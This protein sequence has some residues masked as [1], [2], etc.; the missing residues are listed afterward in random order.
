M[1]AA[2]AT[3]P[4]ITPAMVPPDNEG[5]AARGRVDV[6]VDMEVA[7]VLGE[8]AVEVARTL[9]FLNRLAQAVESAMQAKS[10]TRDWRLYPQHVDSESYPH[11][12]TGISLA[13]Y[14]GLAKIVEALMDNSVNDTEGALF[15]ATT[16]GPNVRGVMRAAAENGYEDVIRILVANG[17]D[18]N[19]GCDEDEG[20][21]LQAAAMKGSVL[22]IAAVNG[23]ESITGLLLKNGA[24]PNTKGG[25]YGFA[26]QAAVEEGHENIIQMLLDNGADVNLEGGPYGNAF[27][28]AVENSDQDI[29]ELLLAH[30]ANINMMIGGEKYTA[31]QEVARRGLEPMTALHQA[32]KE[33]QAG[34]VALLLRKGAN[35]NSRDQRGFTALDWA[36]K[37]FTEVVRVL[38]AARQR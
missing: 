11:E 6:A 33:G 34:V 24:D 37:K 23:D 31:L 38:E 35:P 26:L 29:V 30:G 3:E 20:N 19:A 32:A 22:H 4:T 28:A 2:P 8:T 13:A 27:Q 15:W 12:V 18:V 1:A 21:A 25:M 10:I 7:E 9:R 5:A 14:F 36:K 16:G 17:G